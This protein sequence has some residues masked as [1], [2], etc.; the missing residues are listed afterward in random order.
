MR[1]R[2]KRKSRKF[3]KTVRYEGRKVYAEQR[4][5]VD[6]KFARPVASSAEGAAVVGGDE[7][8]LP[9]GYFQAMA[10][11]GEA[12]GQDESGEGMVVGG[13]ELGMLDVGEE[14]RLQ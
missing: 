11:A 8:G 10:S 3:E 6:G 12:A 4:P 9:D 1:Y 14:L 13:E 5:R 7:S 2:E